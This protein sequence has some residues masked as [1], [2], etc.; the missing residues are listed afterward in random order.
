MYLN[1]VVDGTV[2]SLSLASLRCKLF[3][4]I[5]TAI[6]VRFTASQHRCNVDI[7]RLEPYIHLDCT[8]A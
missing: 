2:Y 7:A 5:Q 8:L 1:P 6:K 4:T 3:K